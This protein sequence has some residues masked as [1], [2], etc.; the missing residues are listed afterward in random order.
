MIKKIILI[1]GFFSLVHSAFSQPEYSARNIQIQVEFKRAGFVTQGSAQQTQETN[2]TQVL[3]VSDGLEG[4]LFMGKQLPNV[5]WYRDYLRNEGYLTGEVV[6]REVGSNLIVRPRI[7]GDQIEVTVTPEIS[8]E[9]KDGSGTV[10]V[11]RLSTTVVVPNGQ[12]LE[13]GAGINNSEFESN[14]YT[15]RSGEATRIVLTPRILQ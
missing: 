5:I 12:S 4:H 9:T 15:R 8:Y 2:E 13:I 1:V 3:V 11:K 10:A 7:V 6:F 14:F